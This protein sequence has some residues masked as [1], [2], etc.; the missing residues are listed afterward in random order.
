MRAWRLVL[1]LERVNEEC[2][3]YIKKRWNSRKWDKL[4][5][6]FTLVMVAFT[7]SKRAKRL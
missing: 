7:W 5:N 6:S 3:R 2:L 4:P 1:S